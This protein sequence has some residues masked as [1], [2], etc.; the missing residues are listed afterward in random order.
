[1][2][3]DEIR[4]TKGPPD[5]PQ[6]PS[7]AMP[8]HSWHYGRLSIL[9]LDREKKALIIEGQSLEAAGKTICQVGELR[10]TVLK[11]AETLGRVNV[12]SQVHA[13]VSAQSGRVDLTFDAPNRLAKIELEDWNSGIVRNPD[14]RPR[15]PAT[16]HS[17][18]RKNSDP[19]G[20]LDRTRQAP[21]SRPQ[22]P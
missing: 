21:P 18:L 2:S 5:W 16:T 4:N 9:F 20:P 12:E 6:W 14:Y 11:A 17:K 1:M 8:V 10:P 3:E 15:P 13:V 7:F 19:R 22:R